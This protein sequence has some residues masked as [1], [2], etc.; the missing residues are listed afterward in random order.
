MFNV[1]DVLGW[2]YHSKYRAVN[3][4][5]HVCKVSQI[6]LVDIDDNTPFKS[7]SLKGHVEI[8]II[9]HMKKGQILYRIYILITN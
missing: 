6:S 3:V 4:Y 7:N 9:S 1:L 2:I 5:V 8:T